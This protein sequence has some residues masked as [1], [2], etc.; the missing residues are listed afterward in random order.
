MTRKI[1]DIADE[2]RADW[3]KPNY[4]AVPYLDAMRYLGTV[5]DNFGADNAR[6][7]IVYF[8]GNASTWKGER[9]KAIKAE[10]KSIIGK[11]G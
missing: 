1:C 11:R 8:L 2:I 5:N 3:K 6:S 7:I 9:A 10:L 4:A